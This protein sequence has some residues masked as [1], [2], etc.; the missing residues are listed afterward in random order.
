MAMA[1]ASAIGEAGLLRADNVWVD[2]VIT[3]QYCLSLENGVFQ[4]LRPNKGA[5]APCEGADQLPV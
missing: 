4:K 1:P 5:D 2:F 3:R